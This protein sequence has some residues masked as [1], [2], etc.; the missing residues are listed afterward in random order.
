MASAPASPKRARHDGSDSHM[1]SAKP[2]LRPLGP[3]PQRS[4][5]TTATEAPSSREV[6]RRPQPGVA[7]ADD[8]DV[9]GRLAAQGR[10][11]VGRPRPPRRATSSAPCAARRGGC[12]LRRQRVF[13]VRRSVTFVPSHDRHAGGDLQ[14]PARAAAEVHA[15]RGTACARS[16]ATLRPLMRKVTLFTRS[17][18][19]PLTSS[20]R[21]LPFSR[22][23]VS[24]SAKPGPLAAG[25]LDDERRLGRV[26]DRDL[27]LARVLQ[28]VEAAD[29]VRRQHV[30]VVPLHVPDVRAVVDERREEPLVGGRAAAVGMDRARRVAVGDDHAELARPDVLARERLA[31][32]RA[33]SRRR[34]SPT[35]RSGRRRSAGCAARTSARRRRACAAFDHDGDERRPPTSPSCP[36]PPRR[37]RRRSG[38]SRRASRSRWRRR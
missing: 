11:G 4:A 3:W 12:H 6:P 33:R 17:M 21:R 18:P 22:L 1:S 29:H 35:G 28:R 25:P 7:A 10:G 24:R 36:R 19:V 27:L 34:G 13:N 15:S 20:R 30:A 31:W 8:D 9:R 5:S 37:P 23:R 26:V 14:R 38:R 16:T 2:P 32:R